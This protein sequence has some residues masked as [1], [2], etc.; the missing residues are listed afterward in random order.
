MAA[1]E[2]MARE[3]SLYIARL[4]DPHTRGW[5]YFLYFT[6]YEG[7]PNKLPQRACDGTN[8]LEVILSGLGVDDLGRLRIMADV[9]RDSMRTV[10]NIRTTDD[11]LR[12]LGI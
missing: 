1:T 8:E 9:Q 10:L 6:P 12:E 11:R 2:P 5:R 4:N 7:H 3:G